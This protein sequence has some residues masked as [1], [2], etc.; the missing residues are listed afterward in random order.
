MCNKITLPMLDPISRHIC[1]TV[2][3]LKF[4]DFAIFLDNFREMC[5]CQSF[6]TGERLFENAE[7]LFKMENH[8]LK[9]A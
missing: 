4:F 9:F 6:E 5:D 8:C 3:F 7:L 1:K 2:M